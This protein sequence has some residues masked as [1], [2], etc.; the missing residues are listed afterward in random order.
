MLEDHESVPEVQVN[1]AGSELCLQIGLRGDL[2]PSTL[3]RRD[4][5][6]IGKDHARPLFHT[7]HVAEPTYGREY[8]VAQHESSTAVRLPL[9][10]SVT[11]L[12]SSAARQRPEPRKGRRCRGP[13]HQ[14]EHRPSRSFA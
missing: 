9:P 6:P 4:D 11:L 14:K 5:I 8:D 13:N 7:Q 12:Y 3:E 10:K 1:R 2:D